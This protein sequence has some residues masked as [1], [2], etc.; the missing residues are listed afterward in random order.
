MSLITKL[1]EAGR[2]CNLVSVQFLFRRVRMHHLDAKTAG[3]IDHLFMGF[4]QKGNYQPDSR[5]FAPEYR[6]VLH[7]S[8]EFTVEA[9]DDIRRSKPLPE[10][11]GNIATMAFLRVS[12]ISHD[13]ALK[14]SLKA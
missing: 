6:D 3:T 1:S 11:T 14:V 9:L 4:N 7:V 5:L 2:L 10:L 8:S 13:G 12:A